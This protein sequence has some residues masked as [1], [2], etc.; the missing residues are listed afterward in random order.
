MSASVQP[1]DAR[2]FDSNTF[3][4]ALNIREIFWRD[5]QPWLQECG[6]MLRSRYKPD[7]IPSWLGTNKICYSVEDGV[8]ILPGIVIDAIRIRDNM[9]VALKLVD[10][11]THEY[12]RRIAK[13][14]SSPRFSGPGNHCVP[15]LEDLKVP[16]SETQAILVMPLL[17]SFLDPRFDTFGEVID[18]FDQIFEGLKY[19]HNR[20]M[21]H[22]DCNGSNIMMDGSKMFPE[23][24]HPQFPKQKRD[25][26]SGSA[27]FYTRTQCP[28]KYYFTDLGISRMYTSKDVIDSVIRGGDRSVPEYK[29]L[30]ED[31]LSVV[32]CNP[33]P[34]DIYF[35]GNMIRTNFLDGD[36]D[37]DYGNRMYGLDFMRPL[38]SDMT[39][40]DPVKRPTIDEV[41]ERFAE[42]RKG[43]SC[44]KLR[45]R[46]VK[47]KDFPLPLRI[48]KH[49]YL[50][51]G[52][53]LR[54][55]P[56][57]PVRSVQE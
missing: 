53:I 44:W 12:E 55:V 2:P 3:P 19:M 27:K 4:G 28:P 40:E 54:R 6:Y 50:R 1:P 51:V 34:V 33:F 48:F 13:I 45:S 35:L 5:H 20:N 25:I 46:V 47:A 21:A 7:W 18:F 56:A 23:G 49:W 52:Y 11:E 36:G 42:I 15:L 8:S 22:R 39:A 32:P 10:M 24:F 38:V 57:I 16:D 9:D 29:F 17:R 26:Y 31:G 30:D 14:C 41:V 37:E 43:L